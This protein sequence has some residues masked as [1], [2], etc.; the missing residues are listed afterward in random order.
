MSISTA[1]EWALSL[2]PQWAHAVIHLGKDV[3]NRDW[4]DGYAAL[5]RARKL[6]GNHFLI[7]AG[8]GKRSDYEAGAAWIRERCLGILPPWS[9]VIRGAIVGSAYLMSVDE[10]SPSRWASDGARHLC[11]SGVRALGRPVPAPGALGFF[12]PEA[13]VLGAV[14]AQLAAAPVAMTHRAPTAPRVIAPPPDDAPLTP[15]RKAARTRLLRAAANGDRT[16]RERL[17]ALGLA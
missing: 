17:R 16:A 7:H 15:G 4:P 10:D 8:T 13:D 14:R 6:I 5:S 11:L 2:R 9:D 3:E 1:P 12:R